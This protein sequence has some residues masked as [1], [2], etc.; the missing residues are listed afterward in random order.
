M[1]M[2]PSLPYTN[3]QMTRSSQ[4]CTSRSWKS[5]DNENRSCL[6][7]SRTLFKSEPRSYTRFKRMFVKYIEQNTKRNN[8]L[9]ELNEHCLLLLP[10]EKGKHIFKGWIRLSG[11]YLRSVSLRPTEQ[12]ECRRVSTRSPSPSRAPRRNSSGKKHHRR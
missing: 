3:S 12:G 11:D 8:S 7:A 5:P 10:K 6:C 2:K 1:R 9:L 4:F